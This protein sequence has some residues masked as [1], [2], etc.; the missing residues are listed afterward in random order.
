MAEYKVLHLDPVPDSLADWYLEEEEETEERYLHLIRCQ[1]NAAKKFMA[2]LK[3]TP[4]YS[5]LLANEQSSDGQTG[6][7]TLGPPQKP[8]SPVDVIGS[9][10]LD[11][12]QHFLRLESNSSLSISS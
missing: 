5:K 2:L 6:T 1:R 10:L 8:L 7:S 12:F 3:A 9:M 11:L 4:R